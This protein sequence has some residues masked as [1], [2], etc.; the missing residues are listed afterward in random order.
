MMSRQRVLAALKGEATDRPLFCP[1]VYEHKAR[2]IDRSPSEVCR[3]S[4]LLTES[5]LAE[6][7]IYRPDMLTV[8]IDIY[9]IE[10]EALGCGVFYP[11]TIDG[12]PSIENRILNSVA[13]LQQ[14]HPIDPQ[15]SCRMP[16]MIEAAC[17]VHQRLGSEVFVRACVSGPFTIAAELVGIE[18]LLMAMMLEPQSFD[19]L[20][21]R[22]A[23]VATAY[24]TA[25]L[26][27]GLEV[28]MFDSQAAPPLVPPDM[29]RERIM[30]SVRRVFA[31]Y[32]QAGATFIEYV[33]GGDTTA[34]AESLYASG[35]DI[36]LS[37]F[38]SDAEAFISAM[39]QS[40]TL[41]RRNIDPA[42]IEA[43]PPQDIRQAVT[44]V[45]D[46]CKRHP[47]VMVGSGVLAY[48]TPVDHVELVREMVID[49]F[50]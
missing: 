11:D 32:K 43:S 13:E 38:P 50:A 8:G 34:N 6:Y 30:P 44:E 41:L 33:I 27:R 4:K 14:L 5:V 2:L 3:D 19:M 7:D 45:I 47:R 31:T 36:V 18:Q 12:V 28:C 20:L 49:A 25:F 42:I 10:A 21:E 46:L 35:A 48:N 1:A 26:Q 24:G 17:N 23:Q 9:S 22:C 39:P 40:G 29:F 37:D 15:Q 16:M